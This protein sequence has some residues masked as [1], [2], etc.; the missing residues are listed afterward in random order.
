MMC[1]TA[2]AVALVFALGKIFVFSFL[3]I[4]GRE[5]KDASEVKLA[6]LEKPMNKGDCCM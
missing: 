5:T 1:H 2:I 6:S 4:F 3:Y